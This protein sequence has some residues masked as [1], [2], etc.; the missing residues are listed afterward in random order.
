M[1]AAVFHGRRDVRTEDVEVPVPGQGELLLRIDAAGI[2][3]T[4]AAEFVQGPTLFVLDGPHPVTGHEGPLIPGHELSGRVE[5]AGPGVRGFEHGELVTSVAAV[6]CGTCR[7]CRSGRTN[8]CE[9]YWTVGLQRHGGLAQYCAVPATTCLSVEPFGLTADAAALAQPMSIAVHAFHR[10]RVSGDDAV[11]VVGVGGIGAFL[12]YVA[13]ATGATVMALDTDRERLRLATALGAQHTVLVEEDVDLAESLISIG[14][15][16]LVVF[17]VSG[18]DGG[19]KAALQAMAAGDRLVVVGLQEKARSL[20]LAKLALSE[21][22]LIGTKAM[23]VPHD[24][25]EAVRLL[26]GRSEPW[27]DVAPIALPLEE[28]VEEGL[29]PLAE[30]RSGRVKTLIDPWVGTA[31]PTRM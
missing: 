10:G 28:L 15:R 3:G 5:Q 23:N 16:H 25:E 11:V 6:S 1:R 27:S 8:L 26:A 4:D 21:Q 30:A 22:E 12:T 17:E 31:R 7:H 18:T 9:T 20:D 13:S 19:L 2:C 24:L 29:R 14:A